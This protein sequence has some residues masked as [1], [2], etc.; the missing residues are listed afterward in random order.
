MLKTKQNVW[1]LQSTLICLGVLYLTII[2]CQQ[3]SQF[4][5]TLEFISEYSHV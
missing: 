4:S 2:L 5:C 3:L 1:C